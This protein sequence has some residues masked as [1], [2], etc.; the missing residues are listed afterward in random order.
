MH[1]WRSGKRKHRTKKKENEL[2]PFSFL[3]DDGTHASFEFIKIKE[4]ENE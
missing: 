2:A 3:L 1:I 4:E